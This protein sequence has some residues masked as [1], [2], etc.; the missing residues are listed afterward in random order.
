MIQ[1]STSVHQKNPKVL[2]A[3]LRGISALD[4][5]GLD[6]CYS[7]VLHNPSGY[8]KDMFSELLPD[9][10]LQVAKTN[11]KPAVRSA[12]THLWGM[13]T[14]GVVAAIKN[15]LIKQA[16]ERGADIFFCDSDQVLQPPTL[17][18]LVEQ[19][20]DTIGEILWTSWKPTESPMPNCWDYD[21]YG[22]HEGQVNELREP[23]VYKVG[24]VG[25]CIFLSHKAISDGVSYERIPVITTWG[26]D[27]HLGIRASVLGY[28]MWVDTHY[29]LFHIY[30]DTDLQDLDGW[31]VE[32]G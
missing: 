19:G 10:D 28:Q 1:I 18:H 12:F 8:E 3:Y 29:P 7:F 30:R 20:K 15:V 6:V 14:V 25:G 4:T 23:G 5:E 27:R 16:V 24:Y 13:G 26:E 17:K 9:A 22:F 31:L 2:E 21:D 32:N 11:S